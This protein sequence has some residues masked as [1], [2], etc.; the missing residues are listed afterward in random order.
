M[1]QSDAA[2]GALAVEAGVEALEDF[3]GMP[4]RP[5]RGEC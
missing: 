3:D 5:K 2:F 1:P 4:K